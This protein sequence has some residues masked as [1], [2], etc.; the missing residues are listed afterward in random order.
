MLQQELIWA[1]RVDNSSADPHT[2]LVACLQ[3]VWSWENVKRHHVGQV[4]L[5]GEGRGGGKL[6]GFT[7]CHSARLRQTVQRC[8]AGVL[9]FLCYPEVKHTLV[10][11]IWGLGPHYHWLVCKTVCVMF[12][13]HSVYIRN[14]VNPTVRRQSTMSLWDGGERLQ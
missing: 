13:P 3:Q 12:S 7:G 5:G 1:E 8:T 6:V 9:H 14:I 4:S 11:L 10:L 2:P